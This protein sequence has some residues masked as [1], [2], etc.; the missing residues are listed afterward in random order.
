MPKQATKVEVNA[1]VQGLITEA[2]PLNFPPNA[3]KDEQNFEL[4]A[5]G[6]RHRRLG[7]DYEPSATQRTAPASQSTVIATE[8]V[9]YTWKNVNG[10]STQ[11]ILVVQFGNYLEFFDMNQSNLSTNG[12][13]N[14]L[15][16]ASFPS[17]GTKF[18]FTAVD[19]RLIVAAGV[20]LIALVSYNE[21]FSVEYM[22][23]RVRDVWGVQTADEPRY[24]V[25]SSF[26]G[27]SS[28]Y[29]YY[30]LQNQSWGI[31]RKN[32]NG[33]L[34]NPISMYAGAFGTNPSNSESVWPALQFQAVSG[35]SEPFER[36]Y[37]NL[38]EETRGANTLSAKGYY[39]IDL[40]DRGISRREEF[41]NN[42][43]KYPTLNYGSLDS[44]LAEDRTL[45]GASLVTE[46]AGRVF[47]GGFNGTLFNGDNRSPNL[48]NFIVFS[49]LVKNRTQ[50]TKCYQEGD[51]TGRD[52]SDVVDTDGGYVRLS[53]AEKI[54]GM[55]GMGNALIVIATNG[56]WAITGGSD[57]GFS[58]TNLRVDKIS[59][60]GGISGTS[61]VEDGSNIYFWAEEAIYL[62]HRNQTNDLIVDN[63]TDKTIKTFYQ[64]IPNT[65]KEVV[66]SGY[67]NI[68]KEI[69]WM[70]NLG[71]KFTG[72]YEAY[73]LK[74]N[75][76]LGAFS[77]N[78]I[79]NKADS[80]TAITSMFSSPKFRKVDDILDVV[81][82]TS[83]VDSSTFDVQIMGSDNLTGFQNIRYLTVSCSNPV[84]YSFSYYNNF[85]FKDWNETDAKA[86]LITGTQTG[87][88]SSLH[89]QVPYV[90]MQFERTESGLDALGEP[91]NASSCKIRSHW[92]WSSSSLSKKWSPL[93]ETYRYRRLAFNFDDADAFDTGFDVLTTRNKVRGR[94]RSFALY[95]ETSPLKDCKILG[96]SLALNG[97]SIT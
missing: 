13:L 65:A 12:Y 74:L 31:P 62:I 3:S 45:S 95:M 21:T 76:S 5:K 64:S 48:S 55:F 97:N 83:D 66:I 59:S 77:V 52:D 11:S 80:V 72:F 8:P 46:F 78:R 84:K 39:I 17:S 54:I 26:R 42:Q 73:E 56:V 93:Y 85:S 81:S 82:D 4:T 40:L 33:T 29:H 96:W 49:Q 50:Y 20:K 15:Q 30:N 51:P 86:Y 67:D 79:F 25:D 34:G 28:P 19:G 9:A 2:S 23:L 18:S 69:K 61:I 16:L 92:D 36:V 68:N 89:K 94:G 7:M 58:A 91:D 47:Y 35:G 88:D 41:M 63:I 71:T 43:V 6:T 87:G 37:T 32:K 14:S 27:I 1:F 38:W 10:D 70:Y 60:Y 57:Y 22:R 53:G 75:I 90:V 24:D 44:V